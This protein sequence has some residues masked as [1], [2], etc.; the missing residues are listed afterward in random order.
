[1]IK[2]YK[3][4]IRTLVELIMRCGSIDNRYVGSIKAIEGIRG[5]QKVQ[6]SYGDNYSKEVSMN[7]VVKYD[8]MYINIEGRADGILIEGEKVIIDEIKTTTRELLMID[9]DYN[10]LHWAQAKCYG[11]IY[12]EEN[13]LDKIHIQLTYYNIDSKD[14]RIIRKE[15][16]YKELKEDFFKLTDEYREWCLFDLK[17]SQYRDASIKKLKFPF[18]KYRQGQRELAVRVYK[19]I[20]NGKKCLAQAPTGTGKTVSTLFP[21]IKAMGEGHTSK[22][23]YLTA[24]T[25]TREVAEKT[26]DLMREQELNIKSVT[27]TAK[28]KICKMDEVNCNPEYCPYANGYYD[29]INKALKEIISSKG[30]FSRI[31]IDKLSDEYMLCPFELSLELTLFADIIICDYNYVFDPKVYLKRFFDVKETDYSLLIDE[32]HNLVD[33]TR[34][35]YTTD[36]EE[37]KLLEIK[38]KYSKKSKK[39]VKTINEILLFFQEKSIDLSS[40]KE[41][42][43]IDREEPKDLYSSLTLFTKAADEFLS[44]S[45]DENEELL[46]LYFSIHSFLTISEYYDENF[47]TVY[48]YYNKKYIAIKLFCVNPTDIINS[49]MQ[50]VKANIIF[51]ATLLPMEYFKTMYSFG[52]ED[53]LVNLRSPFNKENRLI[54]IGDNV[55]TTYNMREE[56]CE[57]II[58]YINKC[59][60]VKKGNYMVFFPSYQYMNMV[61][62]KLKNTNLSYNLI[63]QKSEMSEEDKEDF[64]ASFNEDNEKTH[65]GFCVLGS[66]FSEGIDLTNDRLIGV[67]IVGVGMPKLGGDRDIIKKFMNENNKGFDFA[68]VYPGIIKV[69]QAAGRC[70]RTSND[71]GLI[72]LLDTRYGQRKYRELLPYDWNDSKIVRND[73]NVEALVKKFWDK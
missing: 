23:F 71:R 29:R 48:R 46:E 67:I 64:L 14:T 39:L 56:S 53:Y 57:K 59:I 2:E 7:Y 52:E 42:V 16:N 49:K 68:Y 54:L 28:D 25:I 37:E 36:L 60:S 69:L 35:M 50:K 19:A 21:A 3:I 40:N 58:K 34:D 22:I 12:C 6:G 43:I 55:A 24:K 17:W 20:E 15:Y 70:I 11:F 13:N 9:E 32:A 38:K 66:H 61:Y 4:S 41:K 73:L 45:K 10:P 33:R 31:S 62:D 1:M 51:S 27:V 18:E 63:I 65:L 47:V 72:M 8:D 5:H 44:N 30:N 26:I